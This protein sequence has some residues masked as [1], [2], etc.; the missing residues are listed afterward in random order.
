MKSHARFLQCNTVFGYTENISIEDEIIILSA[1]GT[2]CRVLSEEIPEKKD[3]RQKEKRTETLEGNEKQEK[4]ERK[5]RAKE[6]KE[7]K[8]KK[9]SKRKCKTKKKIALFTNN[10]NLIMM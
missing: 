8:R 1:S 2:A 3:N 5:E 9:K 6:R 4:K 7:K 10:N